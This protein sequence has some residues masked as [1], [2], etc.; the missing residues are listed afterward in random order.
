MRKLAKKRIVFTGG[1]ASS[2]AFV[3]FQEIKKE[4]KPWDLYWIGLK[5]SLEGEKVPPLSTLFFPKYG[6]MTYEI[7]TGRIQRK[8]TLHTIPSLIRIP[9]SF[10]QVYTLLKKIRPHLILSFGGFAAF[11][12]VVVGFL[13]KIP[14]II[15]EQTSVVGRANRL[16]AFFAR[17]IAI[18]RP[19]S[20]R[21][22][23]KT[24]TL[25]IGNPIPS[26]IISEEL[27]GLPKTPTIFITGG[28]TGAQ[29]I[30]EVV[31]KSL[32]SLLKRFKIIHQTGLKDLNKFKKI[33]EKLD[34]NIRK[35]Y[36]VY[37]LV[38]FT[39]YD[40]LF[41]SA[42]LLISRAGANTVAKI[43]AAKKPAILIPLPISYLNEQEE[44]AIYARDFGLARVIKQEKL[45]TQRLFKEIDYVLTHWV[46][47]QKKIKGKQS[48]DIFASEK[49]VKLIEEEVK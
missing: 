32:S 12:V 2:T 10:L 24:K 35:K 5:S 28:Q 27:K 4:K 46:S 42:N 31:A 19:S 11:P 1:H 7:S 38:D 8:F 44:N 45:T 36:Q 48:P 22:F 34:P 16:S 26:D 49:I 3:V 37:G 43:L 9:F 41:K 14:I 17:K 23:P 20:F 18:S 13:L 21:Y 39:K 15:H 33:R 40:K 47:I 29:A 6:I 30:N 25:L